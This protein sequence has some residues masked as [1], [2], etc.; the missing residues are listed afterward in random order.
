[1][2]FETLLKDGIPSELELTQE[3]LIEFHKYIDNKFEEKLDKA[4]MEPA[5]SLTYE[6]KE[7]NI[8]L[9]DK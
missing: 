4:M 3:E 2:D 8:T 9:T 1:M 5:T 6:G 7:I